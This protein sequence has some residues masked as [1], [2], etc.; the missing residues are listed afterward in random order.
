MPKWFWQIGYNMNTHKWC[1]SNIFPCH[2]RFNLKTWNEVRVVCCLTS[3]SRWSAM[4]SSEP[5]STSFLSRLP[6]TWRAWLT[7]AIA[8]ARARRVTAAP[9]S[10]VSNWRRGQMNSDDRGCRG[11]SCYTFLTSKGSAPGRKQKKDSSWSGV[12]CP[13]L[14]SVL[15]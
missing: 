15:C 5:G 14:C 13:S 10:M 4:F 2:S 3:P 9:V 8:N 11:L 7:P 12:K 6:W 1:Y